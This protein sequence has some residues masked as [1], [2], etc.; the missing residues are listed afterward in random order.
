MALTAKSLFLFDY[1]IT[2]LNQNL[3][4]KAASLGPQLTAIIPLGFYSATSLLTAIS[5]AMTAADP[6]NIYSAAIDRTVLAG[7]QNRISIGTNGSFLSLLFGSGTHL[8][9]SIAS[10]VGFSSID[11]TGSTTYTGSSTTGTALLTTY[12]GYNYLDDRNQ[13]KLFGAVNI[14]A[15]GL[16]EATVFNIQ[17]FIDVEFKYEAKTRLVDW[18]TFFFWAIQQRPFD[19]TP[20]IT[21]PSTVF[22]LT[23]ERTSYEGKGLGYQMREMLPNFPN[24]YQTGPL[25][26]R[27]IE[28]LQ[29][30]V[31]PS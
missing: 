17:K 14:A 6:A 21:A 25:N 20:E 11:R 9:T 23:L 1:E 4:F 13:A 2:T 29:D 7:L 10:L 18:R 27:I 28:A 16:K 26:F 30:F 22:Q 8:T 5:D 24:F 15:S 12:P 19:F 3:D 31:P